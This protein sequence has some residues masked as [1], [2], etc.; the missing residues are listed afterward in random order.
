M[1]EMIEIRPVIQ[2]DRAAWAALFRDYMVFYG[3]TPSDAVLDTTWGWIIDP[4]GPM[5][6]LLAVKGDRVVGFAQYR[7]VPETLTGG[8]F[9]Q[10]DD[11]FVAPKARRDGVAQALMTR[12]D[13][14][15]RDR[16]WFKL[17]WITAD[18][19]AT[20]QRLYDQIG[21]ASSWVVYERPIK[22]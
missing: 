18:D 21:K 22:D 3:V 14:I 12:L 19:N 9:G 10:L 13:D 6:C 8:W 5:E 20:A 16:G 2:S 17:S 11:L 1:A 7:A 15:A 4:D